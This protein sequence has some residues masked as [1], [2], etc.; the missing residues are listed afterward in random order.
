MTWKKSWKRFVASAK[1][2]PRDVLEDGLGWGFVGEYEEAIQR[3]DRVEYIHIGYSSTKASARYY[4]GKAL[5]ELGKHEEAISVFKLYLE[6]ENHDE[7]G[8]L[9][10]GEE[11]VELEKFNEA[12]DC[13]EKALKLNPKEPNIWAIKAEPL[14]E[15]KRFEEGLECCEKALNLDPNNFLAI[16]GRSSIYT[17]QG[18]FDKTIE[19]C[20]KLVKLNPDD[21]E[22]MN[23]LG[24][25]YL[26]RSRD[27]ELEEAIK[28]VK[29]AL[30]ID[31]T[32]ELFW[33][34]KACILS[35]MN[36]KEEACDAL[37]VA[38]SIE[39]R[40]LVSMRDEEN[41]D[42]IKNSECFKKLL[43]QPV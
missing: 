8:W 43:N 41:F 15:L 5:S 23:L 40:N 30:K 42:N 35:L 9:S 18:K 36:K 38:T 27:L 11:Y 10:L 39:P 12:L 24:V 7:F 3:F 2:L 4:K 28:H 14:T 16:L 33:Y 26:L 22:A 1:E 37:L 25:A 31:P 34:N 19:D 21:P 29:K 32:E 13:Y 6:K 20:E 17:E